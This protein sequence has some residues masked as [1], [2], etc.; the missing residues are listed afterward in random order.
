M[1]CPFCGSR[2]TKHIYSDV[3]EYDECRSCWATFNV[4]DYAPVRAEH[5]GLPT[6]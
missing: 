1:T 4:V 6:P 5:E 2:A 3:D